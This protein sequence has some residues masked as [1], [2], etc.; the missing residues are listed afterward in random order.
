[1]FRNSRAAKNILSASIL[2]S[3]IAACSK[4]KDNSRGDSSSTGGY[5]NIHLA[6][7]LKEPSA[8][9]LAGA[10]PTSCHVQDAPTGPAGDGLCISAD[11]AEAWVSGIYIGKINSGDAG[12]GARLLGGGSGLGKDGHLE[13][14]K[15]DLGDLGSLQGE[16]TLWSIYDKKP[17]LDMIHIELQYLKVF[18]TIKGEKWEMLIPYQNQSMENDEW[19][20][21]CY[22]E[23]YRTNV[24]TRANPLPGLNFQK[25]DYL[26]C[27]PSTSSKCQMG[28]FRWFDK[29]TN[30]LTSTRP[31]APRRFEYLAQNATSTCEKSPSNGRPD[32][33]SNNVPLFALIKQPLFKLYADFSHGRD[34]KTNPQAGKPSDVSQADWD[35]HGASGKP[36]SPHFVYFLE[37]NGEKKQGNRVNVKFTFDLENYLFLNGIT[38]LNTAT[39]ENVLKVITTKDIF[40]RE[41]TSKGNEFSPQ[42]PVSVD[43]EVLNVPLSE[44]YKVPEPGQLATPAD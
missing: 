7:A 4:K 1:M 26:F 19:V 16:D 44:L 25:G 29:T 36:Q 35:A 40:L 14:A 27:K 33:K 10:S 41:G 31:T 12:G 6:L 42:L 28:D 21:G 32:V 37:K 5:S 34:S 22:D 39:T 15:F 3:L 24:I 30:Q 17:D 9:N 13:G 18:F 23:P 2:L 8:L 11:N 38:D 20:K 43:V